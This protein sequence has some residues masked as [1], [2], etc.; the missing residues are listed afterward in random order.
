MVEEP[1]ESMCVPVCSL[2]PGVRL[3]DDDPCSIYICTVTFVATL[4]IVA[5]LIAFVALQNKILDAI[6]PAAEWLRE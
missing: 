5:M 3:A 2:P 1:A 6:T 4:L